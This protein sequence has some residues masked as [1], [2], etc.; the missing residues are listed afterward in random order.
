MHTKFLAVNCLSKGYRLTRVKIK[1]L[2]TFG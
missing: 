2:T 1:I